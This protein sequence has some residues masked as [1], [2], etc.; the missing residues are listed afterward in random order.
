MSFTRVARSL[1]A[2]AAL[3]CP[4]AGCGGADYEAKPAAATPAAP[5]SLPLSR[6][7]LLVGDNQ[8]QHLFGKGVYERTALADHVART[9]VRPV[10]LDMFAHQLLIDACRALPDIPVIHLGDAAN[11][12]CVQEIDRTFALMRACGVNRPWVM[13]PGNHDAFLMGSVHRTC[14]LTEWED[15][16]YDVGPY[17][18]DGNEVTKDVLVRRILDHIWEPHLGQGYT[19]DCKEP[20]DPQRLDTCNRGKI[21]RSE[22]AGRHRDA[23]STF[24]VEA[25]FQVDRE[26]PWRSFVLQLVDVSMRPGSSPPTFALVLDTVHYDDR[27]RVWPQSQDPGTTGAVAGAQRTAIRE[28]L[29]P[30]EESH[31]LLVGHHPLD[32]LQPGT[33]DF[34]LEL[35]LRAVAYVSGHTH[36]GRWYEHA[37]EGRRGSFVELN[38]GSVTDHP[39][40][41]RD[42]RLL[43]SSEA[44]GS[45]WMTSRLNPGRL[46]PLCEPGSLPDPREY[47]AYRNAPASDGTALQRQLLRSQARTWIHFLLHSGFDTG[48]R[49]LL[50][51]LESALALPEGEGADERLRRAC[52]DVASAVLP[53]LDGASAP[54]A[55]PARVEAYMRCVAYDAARH[56]GRPSRQEVT[57]NITCAKRLNLRAA[58]GPFIQATEW[59]QVAD[60]RDEDQTNEQRHE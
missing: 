27:P 40:E 34:V 29:V 56:E 12:G 43:G 22:G 53:E 23:W 30:L 25:A 44:P 11:S 4:T 7:V 13:A 14:R 20:E 59:I 33:Q 47:L 21:V 28:L 51:P 8:V 42:L 39:N 3:L 57:R 15:A 31:L 2:L 10:Q 18:P 16:C 52:F 32:E 58:A 17:G 38:V 48:C 41:Y 24:L 1:S 49:D 50:G 26:H 55:L 54:R 46:R 5:A 37:V 19:L 36:L 60:R 6:P 35:A 9:A 45:V